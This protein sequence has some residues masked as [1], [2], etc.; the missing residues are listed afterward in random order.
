M[1]QTSVILVGD[2][3]SYQVRYPE[4]LVFAESEYCI[5]EVQFQFFTQSTFSDVQLTVTDTAASKSYSEARYVGSNGKVIF[6]ISR[7]LQILL[8]ELRPDTLFD[9]SEDAALVRQKAFS[10][11]LRAF[12][13]NFFTATFEA[14]HG[15]DKAPDRWWAKDRRLRWWTAYPFA[16]DFPNIDTAN[17]I[18]GDSTQSVSFPQVTTSLV[19]SRVRV[20]AETFMQ[21]GG[22][23]KLKSSKD[24]ICFAIAKSTDTGHVE[25][26]SI[27]VSTFNIVD[28]VSDGCP[29]DRRAI[30]LRW[31]NTHGEMVHW[32]FKPYK[33]S[34]TAAATICQR[35]QADTTR[36]VDGIRDDGRIHDGSLTRELT[37]NTGYLQGWEY[38]IVSSIFNA[39][40]VDMLDMES[41]I[42]EE[43][44]R[45]TRCLVKPATYQRSLKNRNDS[46]HDSQ[47]AVTLDLGE[48]RSLV[49]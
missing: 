42:D 48:E 5:V 9:Y 6:D 41:Y 20:K 39:P 36:Y 29:A 4:E 3:F 8:G 32:L 24:G 45:W 44:I 46:D 7:Y 43:E 11:T 38:D 27:L 13:S 15:S 14:C 10:I 16:F 23:F 26:S 12:N 21:N 28:I 49:L 17:V 2:A 18:V 47:I 35:A 31:L 25:G 1:R 40:F 30:Y 34:D 37:A 33:E 22:S 19:H